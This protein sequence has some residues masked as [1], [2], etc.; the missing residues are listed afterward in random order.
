MLK[1][2][3]HF[4]DARGSK[5]RDK[6]ETRGITLN[7]CDPSHAYKKQFFVELLAKIMSAY[8]YSVR[9][10]YNILCWVKFGLD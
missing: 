6:M 8:C 3:G 7:G 5:S 2:G 10:K 4:N 1:L 9:L